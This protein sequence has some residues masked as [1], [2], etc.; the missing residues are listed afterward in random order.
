ML[1]RAKM[2][3]LS[4][5][6]TPAK[7]KSWS[8]MVMHTFNPSTQEAESGK[9][10]SS[11]P[12]W[13]TEPVPGTARAIQQKLFQRDRERGE[14]SSSHHSIISYHRLHSYLRWFNILAC[15]LTCLV[16]SLAL[17]G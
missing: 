5:E 13:S 17:K 9:S 1:S 4:N 15:I 7:E 2:V 6:D 8:G 16:V 3:A 11:R 10:L 12:A 14:A